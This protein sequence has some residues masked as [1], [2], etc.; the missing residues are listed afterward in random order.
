MLD[1]KFIRENPSL[2]EKGIRSKNSD[3]DV[4]HILHIDREYR[5]RQQQVQALHEKR[6][7]LNE[8]VK[9][10]PNQWDKEGAQSLKQQL[11]KE[12]YAL[13]DLKEQLHRLLLSLPNLPKGDV[14]VGEDE[15]KNKVIRKHKEPTK[16]RFQPKDHLTLGE[17]L[18]LIDVQ[19]A[20]KV[21][22][23]RFGYLK[24]EAVLMEFALV[25]LA[26]E[27]L[28]KEKFIPILPPALIRP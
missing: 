11:E 23:T 5:E 7:T 27:T 8:Q 20:A 12:E 14:P 1:I 3:A 18:G 10:N 17:T 19:R 25:Q 22:G 28:L 26:L 4:S 2:V 16:F 15:L 6:N 21:S 24:N 13:T 9:K